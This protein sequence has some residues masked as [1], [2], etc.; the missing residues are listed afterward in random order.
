[1][2]LLTIRNG[3]IPYFVHNERYASSGDLVL[4]FVARESIVVLFHRFF[5]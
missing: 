2:N 3:N 4:I 1:M 5:N